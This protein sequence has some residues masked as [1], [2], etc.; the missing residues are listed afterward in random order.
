[1]SNDSSRFYG[2]FL[3][4]VGAMCLLVGAFGFLGFLL[5]ASRGL[6]FRGAELL[7]LW[8]LLPLTLGCSLC[9]WASR[10]MR[11]TTPL[12]DTGA[13]GGEAGT[14]RSGKPEVGTVDGLPYK[15][16]FHAASSKTPASY[17]VSTS[18][19]AAPSSEFRISPECRFDRLAKRFGIACELQTGDQE[20]DEACYVRSDTEQFTQDCFRDASNRV[21]VI[22]LK[23]LGFTHVELKKGV[24]SARH[25]CRDCQHSSVTDIVS[26]AARATTLLAKN[27]PHSSPDRHRRAGFWRNTW[28]IILWSLMVAFGLTFLAGYRYPPLEPIVVLAAVAAVAG[29]FLPIVAIA[30]AAL[31]RGTSTSH[32]ALKRLLTCAV[33][34]VP[35]GIFGTSMLLN[36]SLDASPEST[37]VALI[38]EKTTS[39]GKGTN[40]YYV[41]YRPDGDPAAT[42]RFPVGAS[43]WK[44]VVPNQSKLVLVTRAGRLGIAWMVAS[45]IEY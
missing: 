2:L 17:C 27:L 1:M 15:I 34:L 5:A 31:V 9:L 40:F 14:F 36:G 11:H 24:V 3:I 23:Q 42:K 33:F 45:R 26:E 13:S 43:G 18:T 19:G 44:R 6:D 25:E 7:L 35:L 12:D 22:N 16:H 30:A 21:A 4:A 38:T 39:S 37:Q 29:I 32:D 41:H 28:E 8:A 10:V 20:F